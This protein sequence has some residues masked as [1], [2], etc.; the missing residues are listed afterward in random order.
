MIYHLEA[1][2]FFPVQPTYAFRRLFSGNFPPRTKKFNC[3]LSTCWHILY[4]KTISWQSKDLK[5]SKKSYEWKKL[6]LDS[7]IDW[8]SSQLRTYFINDDWLSYI[9]VR[10]DV[11]LWDVIQLKMSD[12]NLTFFERKFWLGN[13]K[14]R[15]CGGIRLPCAGERNTFAIQRHH[16]NMGFASLKQNKTKQ[17]LAKANVRLLSNVERSLLLSLWRISSKCSITAAGFGLFRRSTKNCRKT[18][19]KHDRCGRQTP[20]CSAMQR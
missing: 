20:A 10:N 14:L 15:F 11:K 18:D 17:I 6:S 8:P 1:I 12:K 3:I 2:Y 19:W 5:W 13:E 16:S 9:V 4:W 7:L